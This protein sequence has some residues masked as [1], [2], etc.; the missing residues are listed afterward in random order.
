MTA[1]AL[2]CAAA[3]LLV[4]GCAGAPPRPP[5]SAASRPPP[6]SLWELAPDDAVAGVV[7]RPGAL[8]ALLALSAELLQ[9]DAARMLGELSAKSEGDPRRSD[10]LRDVA[11]FRD[12]G[13]DPSVGAAAFGF[14]DPDRGALLVLPVR[15]RARFRAAFHLALQR[16]GDR[17]RDVHESGYACEPAA[18]LY[19]CARSPATI[20]AALA[21]RGGA[22]RAA[23]ERLSQADRGEVELYVDASAPQ[24]AKA[25]KRAEERG[26]GELLGAS[27]ALR[28]RPDGASARLHVFA[29]LS[30]PVRVGLREKTPPLRPLPADAPSTIR[31]RLDPRALLP[32]SKSL[33]PKVRAELVEPL[34]GDVE[35]STAGTGMIGATAV[36]TLG[37]PPRVEAYVKQR[38]ADTGGTWRRYLLAQITVREHGCSAELDPSLLLLPVTLAPVP[39]SLEVRGGQLLLTVGEGTPAASPLVPGEGTSA[40]EDTFV[41]QS[42]LLQL[43]PEVGA[44]AAFRAVSRLFDER[45]EKMLGVVNEVGAHIYEARLAGHLEADGAVMTLDL[46]T[47]ATDPKDAREAYEGALGK[48]RA[49][50]LAGYRAALAEVEARFPGTKV[51]ERA[52]RVRR[53][54][55]ALGAGALLLSGFGG[56][57]RKTK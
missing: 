35:I 32:L 45:A 13:L 19:L 5:A 49:G 16:E 20:D 37:D 25:G 57:L 29:A 42:R 28:L 21:A 22:L 53:G 39:I 55:P 6:A 38:C 9:G 48:R 30:E 14:A 3:L 11:V 26:I 27:L 44:A 51:A 18:G 1:R 36:A 7:A 46:T 56:A 2:I 10:A 17:E 31:L 50:D 47:F 40:G 54:G 41:A 8:G 4:A 52:T 15:D 33:D 23:V 34:G 12:L 24:L 43:G